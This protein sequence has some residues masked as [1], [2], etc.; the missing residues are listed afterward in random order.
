MS[1]EGDPTR[2]HADPTAGKQRGRPFVKGISPNPLGRPVGA[3]NKLAADFVEA[4]YRD[5]QQHGRQAIID[6]RERDPAAYIKTIASLIP[7]EFGLDGQPLSASITVEF[8]GATGP[9]TLDGSRW[10]E[11]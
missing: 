10:P 11:Q 4:L 6:M 2:R 3:R 9:V 8:V 1:G 7:R 5:F